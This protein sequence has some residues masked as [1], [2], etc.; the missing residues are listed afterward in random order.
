MNIPLRTIL[1]TLFIGAAVTACSGLKKQTGYYKLQQQISPD[2]AS[3]IKNNIL[4]ISN[5]VFKPYQYTGAGN[6]TINYR[7]LEPIKP[8]KQH[9]YPLVLILH[10]SGR[11]IG[12]DNK[13]QL[14]VLAKLWAQENI[15]Q[16]YPAY[17]VVPQFPRR[18]SNYIV[19]TARKVLTSVPDSC[20]TA[21]L[22]LIDSL[23]NVLPIDNNRIYVLGFSMGGSS[24]IN[25]LDLRPDLF[26][27]G[28]SISGI[29]D[30]KETAMLASIPLWLIHGN[31]DT[32]NPMGSDSLLYKEL[33]SLQGEH[34]TF[35]EVD[36]L[37]HEVYA[38]LYATDIIPEWLFQQKINRGVE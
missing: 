18:S 8:E 36:H 29:P 6:I 32:E 1:F 22:Q 17:V 12:T 28:I 37:Q 15:R 3:K 21:A 19:D 23:K 33:R 24:T 34:I 25:S 11:P 38:E 7:L 27:A 5:D 35:W 14:G 4:S 16:K 9:Q 26:A 31:A 20:L 10:S 13:S 2:S 30:F